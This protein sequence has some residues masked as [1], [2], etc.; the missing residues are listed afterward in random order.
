MAQGN[1]QPMQP[2]GAGAHAAA[3]GSPERGGG[4]VL[5]FESIN[6]PGRTLDF[7]CDRHG[8]VDLDA[9]GEAARSNYLFA[10]AVVGRGFSAPVVVE[11]RCR[12]L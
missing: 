9:L 4:F 7:P 8:R 10:R 6:Q 2:R 11:E 1:E 3:P 12:E 5:R